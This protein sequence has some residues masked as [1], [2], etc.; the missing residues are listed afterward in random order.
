MV[1]KEKAKRKPRQKASAFALIA[2][3][4]SAFTLSLIAYIT[5]L[6]KYENP[7]IGQA[8]TFTGKNADWE[9]IV[10][11]FPD[12]KVKTDLVIVPVGDFSDG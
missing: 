9:I 3:I 1:E 2:L 4:A 5:S 8:M 6:N 12:D 7:V 10:T 11:A